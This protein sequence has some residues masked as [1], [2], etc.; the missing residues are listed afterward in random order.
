MRGLR[1][2]FLLAAVL[3]LG[4]AKAPRLD[5]L[6]ERPKDLA[7]RDL[8]HGPGGKA[9]LPKDVPYR[10][11]S[12]D[13]RGHSGGYEVLDPSGRKWDVKVGEEAQ[14]ELVLSRVLWAIGYRQPVLYYVAKW[15]M[16]G[17]PEGTERPPPGRFRLQSDHDTDG[18]WEWNENPFV[19][20]PALK[21]LVVVN[22][23]FNNWD[24]A[25]SQNRVYKVEKKAPG[26]RRWYV[27]QDLGAALGKSRMALGT[28][29]DL[30][31]FEGE[32]FIEGVEDGKVRFDF[33]GRHKGLRNDLTPEDVRWACKLL[34]G[35]SHR[36]LDDA[37]RAAGYDDEQR[38]RFLRKIEE[39]IRQ[40]LE[41]GK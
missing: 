40:G 26:P 34:A 15:R 20:T 18:D 11:V 39:K 31:D 6:W 35:L 32:G 2:A 30:E 12:E 23:L 8:F 1:S 36:Q 29:N 17:G 16:T 33:K 9:L 21:G 25:A 28:R 7:S 14:S 4:A 24:L 3:L 38:R 10:F 22:L 27:V 5:A 41:V 19:D 13:K 37:F